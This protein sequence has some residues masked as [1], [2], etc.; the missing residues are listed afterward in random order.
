MTMRLKLS[1]LFL[2]AFLCS[3]LLTAQEKYVFP[4]DVKPLISTRWG[5]QFPFNLLCPKEENDDGSTSYKMAGCGPVAMAQI[6][7]YHRYPSMSPDGNYEYDWEQMFNTMNSSVKKEEIVAV[8]KLISDC[9]V[10]SFTEYGN[11][12]SSTSMSLMMGA[13]K[14]LFKYSNDMAIYERRTFETP[15]RDSLYR[16]LI[17][18]ELKAGRPVLYRAQH[19]KEGGHL[20]IIDGC[21]KQKV[22]VNMGWRGNRDGYYD[23]DDL[24]GYSQ[25]Q[26]LLVNVADSSY[27]VA[28]KEVRDLEAG[29]LS[30]ILSSQERTT[31]QKI[32]LSGNMDTGDFATLRDML[33]TGLLRIIDL[34]GV[35]MESL[36]DS[37]FYECTYLSHFVAPRTLRHTGNYAFFRCRNLNYAVFSDSL[38]V[39]G[40][41]AFSGCNNLLSVKL[42]ETTTMIG[43]N[44]FTSCEALLS[45]TLPEGIWKVGNYA[46]SYC[47]HLY[48]I[49]LPASLSN[50]GNEVFK[51]CGRLTHVRL[52]SDNPHFKVNEQNEVVKITK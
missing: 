15:K 16:A 39:V 26:W 30:S 43:Y 32:K 40:N 27:R 10:S 7:N 17:F 3:Q 11:D 46:F 12:V 14:R 41:A 22:H 2:T 21:K 44:A 33:Q 25:N 48:S 35:A 4:E 51:E 34:E 36:P 52:N 1:T 42:P 6:V 24:S 28:T 20:F 29:T 5:Q 23:L 49:Y 9:G 31:V 19:A 45:V 8:A 50:F 47:K 18:N 37:A 38:R 13:L